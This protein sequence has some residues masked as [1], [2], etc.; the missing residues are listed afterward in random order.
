MAMFIARLSALWRNLL[1]RARVERALDEDV[2]AYLDLLI[3]EKM[4]AGLPPAAARR[5]AA[6]ELEGVEQVKERVRDVRAGRWLERCWQDLVFG[7]RTQLKTPMITAVLVGTLA[8]GIAATSASFSLV[9]GFFMRPLPVERPDRIVRLYNA[10]SNG[11]YF[12]ISYPDFADMRDLRGVFADAVVEEPMAFNI[13]AAGGYERVW[14]ERVSAGYFPLLGVK[15]ALGRMFAPSEESAGEPVVVLS[16][17]FWRRR[18]AGRSA[19]LNETLLLNGDRF[20]IAGVAPAGFSGMLLGLASDLWIPVATESRTAPV[21]APHDRDLLHSRGARGFFGLARLNPNVSLEQARA[22]LDSLGERLQREYPASNSGVRFAA[23]SE[24]DGRI[25]PM[26]RGS[27]LGASTVVVAVAL[28][29]LLI[30]CAN[31]AGLL[32]VRAAGRRTEIGVRLALGATRGRIVAQ[33]LTEAAGLSLAAGGIGLLLAW[34]VTRLLTAIR[35]TIARGAPVTVDVGL[36]GRVLAFSF[37]VTV[38]TGIVFGLT[39]ALEASRSDLVAAL[40]DGEIRRGLGQSRVRNVLLA[41]QV[42]LSMVLIVGGGLFV[43]SLQHARHIDL[44][45]DP[46]GVVTTS[47]DVKLHGYSIPESQRVWDRVIADVRR[48]PRTQSASLTTRAPLDLGIVEMTMGPE[49]YRPAEGRGWPAIG[50]AVIEPAFFRTMKIPVLDGREFSDRDRATSPD[51]VILNDVLAHQFWPGERA[52]GRHV[53]TSDGGRF[54]VVGVVRRTKYFLLGEDPKPYAYF[55]LAQSGPRSLTIVARASGEAG[56]YLRDIGGVVHAI[57]PVV[58]LYDVTTMNE[59]VMLQMA[60][61]IGGA[62]ALTM[63]GLMALALTSLGLY[64]AVAQSVSRRTYEIGVRR[65]LGA[66]DRDIAW[67]VVG[68]AIVVVALGICGGMVAGAGSAR[69]LRRLLYGVDLA[70]PIV[71]GVAPVVLIAVCVLASCVPTW[72]AIRLNAAIALRYE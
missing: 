62:T 19:V 26:L 64:G 15:P 41:A 72:R 48:L 5:A 16:D 17:G 44:G 66:Q 23:L 40:K 60:P 53:T 24:S 28:L 51:V 65:A 30:A 25:F 59:R 47:I 21:E 57:D 43:R 34:Q 58:P 61:T 67:L 1:R 56:T 70:D 6:L 37:L 7:L 9:N 52:T 71:F 36:D 18:F 50:Y 20:R 49:G 32:L 39:P 38:I 22:A 69:L 55:P 31:V 2:R 10:Y 54:E 42:A 46:V 68:H 63:V 8:L 29:V 12:T 33:L 13:G 27:V 45:F 11:Q 3:Q 14:G 4:D 35:V